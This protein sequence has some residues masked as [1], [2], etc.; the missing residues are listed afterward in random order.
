M[1]AER[2]GAKERMS[3][4]Q[5]LIKNTERRQTPMIVINGTPRITVALMLKKTSKD[6][7]LLINSA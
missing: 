5:A 1:P 7:S 2:R 6:A 3:R 4:S